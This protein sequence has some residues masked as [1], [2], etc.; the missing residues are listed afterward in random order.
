MDDRQSPQ[1]HRFHP[2]KKTYGYRERDEAQRQAFCQQLASYAPEQLVY[3]DETGVDDTEDYGYGWCERGERFH[4]LKLGHRSQRVSMIAGWCAGE[5]IAPL[6]F[7]GYCNTV[8]V[9]AWVERV[10]VPELRQGQLVIIDNASFH[11][12]ARTRELI[13]AAGCEL[14]FLP[15]YSPDL[16]KIEKFWARLKSF[17]RKSLRQIENLWDAVDDAFRA[18]S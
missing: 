6:T 1:S 11:K 5:A 4:E 2:Q 13:E 12:S 10:L 3:V 17:L 14:V 8:L 18:L 7:E 15:P 9:E 16:N